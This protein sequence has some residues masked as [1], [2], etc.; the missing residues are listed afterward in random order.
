MTTE[1]AVQSAVSIIQAYRMPFF[2]AEDRAAVERF[3]FDFLRH[4]QRH[5]VE[6]LRALGITASR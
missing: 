6:R 4:Y 3:T 5:A 1:S 2:F